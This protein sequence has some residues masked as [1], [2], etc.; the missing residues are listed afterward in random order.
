MTFF[1]S[2]CD[3][4]GIFG[5][6]GKHLPAC[7]F[8]FTRC[9]FCGRPP[10]MCRMFKQCGGLAKRGIHDACKD[11]QLKESRDQIQK[12]IMEILE[13]LKVLLGKNPFSEA[14]KNKMFRLKS[15]HEQLRIEVLNPSP[16][17]IQRFEDL[18]FKLRRV[19]ITQKQLHDK[20]QASQEPLEQA[21]QQAPQQFP[22][23]QAEVT[24]SEN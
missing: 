4:F 16:D 18:L 2:S 24:T 9:F 3:C 11:K 22:E 5:E 13:K 6:V 12:Q 19:Y 8:K 23:Q 15:Q 10:F 17:N 1:F 21:A 14:V 7:P 20:I